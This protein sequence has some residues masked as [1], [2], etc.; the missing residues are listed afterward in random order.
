M[1]VATRAM[2]MACRRRNVTVLDSDSVPNSSV[3]NLMYIHLAGEENIGKKYA[4]VVCLGVC[5]WLSCLIPHMRFWYHG[6][7]WELQKN[8]QVG[9]ELMSNVPVVL[10]MVWKSVAEAL[11]FLDTAT[12]SN[13]L[14]FYDALQFRAVLAN[15]VVGRTSLSKGMITLDGSIQGQQLHLR[16][17]CIKASWDNAAGDL[18]CSLDNCWGLWTRSP[19]KEWFY[20]P[21]REHLSSL[22]QSSSSDILWPGYWLPLLI[23]S[24][25]L[26][27]LVVTAPKDPLHVTWV[28]L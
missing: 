24:R 23:S 28:Y 10:Q 14:V 22:P 19:A 17:G 11:G 9:Q 27:R 6:T 13:G 26:H 2:A 5:S 4:L 8:S 18:P 7:H 16:Q 1:R 25:V 21:N 12:H 15:S 20:P 3:C